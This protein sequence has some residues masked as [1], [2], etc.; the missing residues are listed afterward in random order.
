MRQRLTICCLLLLAAPLMARAQEDSVFA[1][2]KKVDGHF[3]DFWVDNL[4]NL[5]LLTAT[6]QFKKFSAKG[7]SMGVFNDVRRYGKLSYADVS[8]PLKIQ[9]Y[10]QN[11]CTIVTLD[12]FL[13]SRNVLDLRKKQLFKVKAIATAYDNNLWIID[14]QE[15]KLKKLDEKGNTLFETVDW[16]QLFDTLPSPT[17]IFDQDGFLYL[18]D[19][20]KGFYI[21]DYY[22]AFKN[23]LSFINWTNTAV[24][25]GTLYGFQ[26]HQLYSYR[27]GSLQLKTYALPAF[28]GNYAAIK[29]HGGKVYLLKADG[30]HIYRVK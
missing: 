30:I 16:R 28:F 29:V 21:F 27:T 19:P 1:F 23:K 2:E 15:F 12:R 20:A 6:N 9:L 11:F 14:E 13:N 24:A 25:G 22:G 18:Y 4:G 17:Q 5:Y 8:N 10:Y 26:H 7:D 3:T